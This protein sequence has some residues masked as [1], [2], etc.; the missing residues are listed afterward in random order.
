MRGPQ[1]NPPVGSN[2]GDTAALHLWMELT[3]LGS[4]GKEPGMLEDRPSSPDAEKV[5]AE[6]SR[7]YLANQ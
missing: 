4:R 3:L 6:N 7:S 2:E 1:H 5:S